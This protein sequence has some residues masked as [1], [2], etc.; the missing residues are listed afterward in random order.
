MM[1]RLK[2]PSPVSSSRRDILLDLFGLALDVLDAPLDDV[3]DR[4]DAVELA[5]LLDRDMAEAASGHDLHD[6]VDA[7][8][9]GAAPDL[10]GHRVAHGLRQ[11]PRPFLGDDAHDVALR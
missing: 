2:L 7:V 9:F 3:A 5:V 11:R 10:G 1:E 6:L 4:D 8:A